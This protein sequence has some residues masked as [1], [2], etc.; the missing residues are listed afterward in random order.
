M[1]QEE[2][3]STN[4][5]QSVAGVCLKE[6]KVLLARHTYGSGNGKLIIPGGYVKF[7]EVPEETL[8]RE[9]LEETGVRVKAGRLLGIRFS[10]KDWY[11]VFAAEYVEGE[12]RSDGDENSEVVWMDV[13]EA[14]KDET[15]PGLTKT[16]I[17]QAL[18]E[19]GFELTPYQTTK[20]GNFLYVGR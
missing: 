2:I 6:G 18:K 5:S 19:T 8:V 14:L 20:Q 10:A 1:T 7:G 11:A 9:Y 17:E 15:V 4:W 16:M 13:E 3:N 12:A